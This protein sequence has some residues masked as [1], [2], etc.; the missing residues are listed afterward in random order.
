MAGSRAFRYLV[1]DGFTE[2][3]LE[4]NPLAVFPEA[5]GIDGATM[6]RIA[7]ELNL[8]ETVFVSAPDRPDALARVRIFTPMQELRFAGHP[9]IGTAFVLT[10][11]G[12]V[13]ADARSIVL[14]EGIGPVPVRLERRADPFLAWLRTPS[15][16]FG[17]TF[18]RETCAR[19]LGLSLSALLDTPPQ[20]V[21][22]GNPFLFVALRDPGLVDSVAL[23]L[24]ALERAVPP[25]ET[26]GHFVFAPTPGGGAYSRMFAPRA[27]IAEDPA[28]GSGTGPLAAYMA[29]HGLVPLRDGERFTS[30]QGVHMGRPSKLHAILHVRAEALE[31]VEVGGSAV[32]VVDATLTLPA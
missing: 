25:T 31:Y 4:G 8:S 26:T 27:G 1:V 23:D 15:I 2:T 30:T 24:A 21:T 11:L 18:D 28:T 7:R 3:P 13:P 32:R 20:I 29:R 9:T 17:E 14:S 6:Q 19:A 16:T 10:E 5:P 22:A 12:R